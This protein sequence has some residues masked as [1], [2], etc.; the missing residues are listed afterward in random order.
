MKKGFGL[1]IGFKFFCCQDSFFFKLGFN[2]MKIMSS[3]YLDIVS[4]ANSKKKIF[5]L[6]RNNVL[7]AK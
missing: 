4:M 5:I 1:I 2:L 7:L 3:K 6:W